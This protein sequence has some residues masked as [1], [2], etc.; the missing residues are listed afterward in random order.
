M[1]N[2]LLILLFIVNVNSN[3]FEEKEP[4][5]LESKVGGWI[6]FDC[7]WINVMTYEFI[8]NIFFFEGP[9]EFPNDYPIPYHLHWKKE[10]R[11]F[12]RQIFLYELQ[13]LRRNE[14]NLNHICIIKLRQ[15]L[16]V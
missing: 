13:C 14:S 3:M 10:V 15:K 2:G 7:E 9:L 6:V 5:Y 1:M 8:K 11:T 16:V 12:S 4:I